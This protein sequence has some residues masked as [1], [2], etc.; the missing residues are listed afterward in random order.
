MSSNDPYY[1]NI[2][3]MLA[4]LVIGV[5]AGYYTAR[6][7]GQDTVVALK[8]EMITSLSQKITELE[9]Q[10]AELKKENVRLN[11]LVDDLMT[12]EE[13]RKRIAIKPRKTTVTKAIQATTTVKQESEK[14]S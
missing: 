14:T 6:R 12:M 11:G 7:N 5:A 4:L 8:N 1:L 9:K 2:V 13:S 10:V 3:I